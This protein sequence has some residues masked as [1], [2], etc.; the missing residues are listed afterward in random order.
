MADLLS[1]VESKAAETETR[2]KAKILGNSVLLKESEPFEAISRLRHLPGVAWLAV[3]YPVGSFGEIGRAAGKLARNYIQ[4][5]ERF[6]VEAEGTG[7]AVG[8][9]A[10]GAATSGILDHVTGAKVSLDKP[11]IK[12][13]VAFDGTRG[14]V[15]VQ[16]SLGPGGAP[17]GTS[18][19]TCLVSGGSH[20]AV[21]AWMAALAGF[22]VRLVHAKTTDTGLLAVARL[23][24][25]LSHRMDPRGL[26]VKVLRGDS[27]LS[28]LKGYVAG[29]NQGIFGGFRLG[30]ELPLAMGRGIS[31]PLYLLP[32]E[33]FSS[34]FAELGIKGD[35]AT[36][37]WGS[38]EGSRFSA[39]SFGGV[40]ADVS[41]LLDGIA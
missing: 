8:A 12:F 24:S 15:G 17:T 22:R 19:V 21:V 27:V 2:I 5:G 6:S 25:E 33:K 13:R 35:D 18:G 38:S 37:D 11:K 39:S 10:A 1:A 32:E 40:T 31:S 4:S 26:T 14:A 28:V 20:S 9:D 23:Y 36:A 34:E 41:D 29:E 3:G 30:H 16:L 7:N